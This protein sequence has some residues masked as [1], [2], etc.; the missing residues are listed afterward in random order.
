VGLGTGLATLKTAYDLSKGVRDALKSREVKL[1]EVTARMIEI[2]DLITEGRSAL[3][4]AQ[5]ELFKKNEELA[6]MRRK[7]SELEVAISKKDE[8]TFLHGVYWRTSQ[9]KDGEDAEGNGRSHVYYDGPFCPLCK[10]VD[11]KAVRM[12]HSGRLKSGLDCYRCE[13]HKLEVESVPQMNGHAK[14]SVNR[15]T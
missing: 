2:Q 7:V 12:N 13:I 4:D 5:E 11:T 9:I 15:V 1:D 3:I 6:S 8:L 14:I 10:D